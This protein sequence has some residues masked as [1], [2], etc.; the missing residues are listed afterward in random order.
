MDANVRA[1]KDAMDI[2]FATNLLLDKN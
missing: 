2:S 1:T